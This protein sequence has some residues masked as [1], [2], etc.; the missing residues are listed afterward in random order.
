MPAFEYSKHLGLI[1]PDQFQA[2]L[3]RFSL[4]R[5]LHA[6][7]I[8]FGLFGQNIFLSSTQ[9]QFVLRGRPHFTWQFPTEQFFAQQLHEK[10]SVP[11]PWP[12]LLDPSEDIFGW[13]YVIMP[14]MP[15]LQLA[16]QEVMARLGK[17]DRRNIARALAENLALQQELTWPF[18]GRYKSE[19]GDVRPFDLQQ[20]LTWPFPTQQGTTA[21]SQS[22]SYSQKIVAQIRQS[23][24]NARAYNDHT[25]LADVEWVEELLASAGHALDDAFQP[26]FVMQDYKEQ[27]V[28]VECLNATWRVSG[29][30]DFMEAHFGDGEADLS[31]AV[32]MYLD[33]SLALAAEFVEAYTGKKPPRPGFAERFPIYM[34]HDRLIIWD[35]FQRIDSLFWDENLTLRDWAS[36]YTS[37]LNLLHL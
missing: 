31:R 1:S 11:V 33:E 27:N 35:Y 4:G 37:C 9:G 3:N 18:A 14:R 28:V 22:I 17:E 32:A 20:E 6:E 26:C 21:Q 29:V 36:P 2:A 30:F 5:F 13:S 23:L 25:T 12:Y 8:P 19:S 7:P 24:A 15:G 34:L 16:D 10:T